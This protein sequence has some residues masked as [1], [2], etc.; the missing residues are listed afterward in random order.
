M[1]YI[2]NN[3]NAFDLETACRMVSKQRLEKACRYRFEILKRESVIAY[4]LLCHALKEEYGITSPPEFEYMETGKPVLCGYPDIHFNISH[5][6][7]GV[8]C[9]LDSKPAGIDIEEIKP[10]DVE[11]AGNVL[12]EEEYNSI[13]GSDAPETDFTVLWTRKE[14]FLKM[15]GEGLAGN[16][17][18]VKTM[19]ENFLTHINDFQGYVCSA[20]LAHGS[21]CVKE[22]S[23]ID[24]LELVDG[25]YNNHL[26]DIGNKIAEP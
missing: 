21:L 4:L 23:E 15:T 10:L 8:A 2:A 1:I 12:S 7:K 13:L 6:R 9:I 19:G 24:S 3:I 5:C 11:V 14:S 22:F 18:E 20:S 17:K 26:N 16:L 25:C